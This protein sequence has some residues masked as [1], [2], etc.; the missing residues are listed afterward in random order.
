M[1][2]PSILITCNDRNELLNLPPELQAL[3]AFGVAM[4]GGA[5]FGGAIKSIII[6]AILSGSNDQKWQSRQKSIS[7][8]NLKSACI[9]SNFNAMERAGKISIITHNEAGH[10]GDIAKRN[11]YTGIEAFFLNPYTQMYWP[12]GQ[13]DM[14]S[15]LIAD[16]SYAIKR[17][18]ELMGARCAILSESAKQANSSSRHTGVSGS[19]KFIEAGCDTNSYYSSSV[20]ISSSIAFCDPSNTPASVSDIERHIRETGLVNEP[21]FN[22]LLRDVRNGRRIGGMQRYQVKYLSEMKEALSVAVNARV[23]F[24]RAG[25]DVDQMSS[26][27]HAFSKELWVYWDT[28]PRE[29]QALFSAGSL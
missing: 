28:V 10:R 23:L 21:M 26:S 19:Y 16:K 6:D 13:D 17:A 24:V 15:M 5:M 27:L 1:A 20:D 11:K 25:V 9:D 2:K 18:F 3:V 4:F 14:Q 8:G 7:N 22:Y 29:V 12:A